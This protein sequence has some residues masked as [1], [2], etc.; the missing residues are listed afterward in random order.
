MV[1]IAYVDESVREG[2]KG[3]YYLMTAGVV[4]RADVDTA[5]T[6]LKK[7]LLPRQDRFHWRNERDP[8]R[9]LAMLDVITE[10]GL[11][12]FVSWDYPVG[13]KRQEPARG[14]C[15]TSLVTDL[16]REGV[17][18][19]V[20]EARE[21]R[22]LDRQDALTISAAREA[23]LVPESLTYRFGRPKE[24]PLLWVADA[25]A[26]AVGEQLVGRTSRYH[27]VLVGAKLLVLRRV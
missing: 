27:D 21:T 9:R 12:A 1:V 19:V 22:Q 2:P 15:L 23:G 24:E 17:E 14:R 3:S 6:M 26:G 16:G 20:I 11:G 7:L 8:E 25:I 13:N 18:E 4:L 10:L 5:A